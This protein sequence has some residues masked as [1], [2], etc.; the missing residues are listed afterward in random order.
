MEPCQQG[1]GMNEKFL[2]RLQG[3]KQVASLYPCEAKCIG[4]FLTLLSSNVEYTEGDLVS[5]FDPTRM[6]NGSCI[7]EL[8]REFYPQVYLRVQK[9]CVR[10][11]K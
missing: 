2:K 5:L 1:V 7:K 11:P 9:F 6:C 8:L 4:F 10:L 3:M